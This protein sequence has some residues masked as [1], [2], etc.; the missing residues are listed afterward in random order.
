MRKSARIA[1]HW[2]T[3]QARFAGPTVECGAPFHRVIIASRC[4]KGD[5][6]KPGEVWWAN[7]DERSPV[8]ILSFDDASEVRAMMVVAPAR[9]NIEGVA[10][11]VSVG[12]EEGLAFEGA[13][14]VALPRSDGITCTWLVTLSRTALLGC[15][16]RLS[17]SKVALLN[18]ALR[19]GD[20]EGLVV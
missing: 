13:L 4:T 16:G 12:N 11:E 7:V 15:A 20:F 14:R 9:T 10:V 17:S 3:R 1:L 18:D 5:W 19:R 2:P 6:V 8:V